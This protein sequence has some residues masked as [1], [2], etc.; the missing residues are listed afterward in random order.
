MYTDLEILIGEVRL[1]NNDKKPRYG[2]LKE[3]V[4]NWKIVRVRAITLIKNNWWVGDV[5]L[6]ITFRLAA[7]I[8]LEIFFHSR[9]NTTHALVRKTTAE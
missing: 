7:V 9:N 1:N 6:I 3:V 5:V 8:K 4:L 2:K